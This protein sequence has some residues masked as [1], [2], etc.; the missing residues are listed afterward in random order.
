M[1]GDTWQRCVGQGYVGRTGHEH[2]AVLQDAVPANVGWVR[3]DW[4]NEGQAATMP[5]P[6]FSIMS[7]AA[8]GSKRSRQ[9]TVSPPCKAPPSTRKPPIQKNGK[10]Q[11][12]HVVVAARHAAEGS[13]RAHD[14]AVGVHHAL[15]QSARSRTYTRPW[16]G[17]PAPP[18][19]PPA[20]QQLVGHRPRLTRCRRVERHLPGPRPIGGT[21]H[22]D[23]AQVWQ[24]RQEQIGTRG[25]PVGPAPPPRGRRPCPFRAS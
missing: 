1:P 25:R 7:R 14:R 16:P 17:R 24:P 23:R 6:S 15:G 3:I 20:R 8:S 2:G 22:P 9:Q 4:I 11:N 18:P 12:E 5:Q 19:P 10:A 13:G 21:R